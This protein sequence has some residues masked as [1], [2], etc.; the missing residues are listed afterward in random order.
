MLYPVEIALLLRLS[1]ETY[2]SIKA[3][4]GLFNRLFYWRRLQIEKSV[5]F[6]FQ[7]D[8]VDSEQH[9]KDILERIATDTLNFS[10]EIRT[11]GLLED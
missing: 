1:S 4:V 8:G 3:N 9:L 6:D 7:I 5:Y 2:Q 10:L 11:L